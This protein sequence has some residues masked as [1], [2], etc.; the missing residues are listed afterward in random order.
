MLYCRLLKKYVDGSVV[1]L[2]ISAML[3]TWTYFMGDGETPEE[4]F[5]I[6]SQWTVS[7]GESLW[8]I[9]SSAANE[10]ELTIEEALDW[11]KNENGLDNDAIYP[12]QSLAIPVEMK[13]VASK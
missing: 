7:E 11:I 2:M 13:G 1:I 5:F 8:V 9:A 10:M 6:T 3:F 4:Q 12:G